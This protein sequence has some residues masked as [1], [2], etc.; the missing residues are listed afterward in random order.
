MFGC[1]KKLVRVLWE[2]TRQCNAKCIHCYSDSGAHQTSAFTK[3]LAYSVAQQLVDLKCAELT[4]TGGEFFLYPHWKELLHFFK[5]K[6]IQ[7]ALVTNGLLV[8]DNILDILKS[9]G[10]AGIGVS[11]DGSNAHTHDTIRQTPG[12]FDKA[13][14]TIQNAQSKKI[15]A[16][17]IT[18]INKLNITEL[19]DLRNFLVQHG[20]RTWQIQPCVLSGRMNKDLCIDAFGFYIMGLFHAQ[21]SRLYPDNRLK[22]IGSPPMGFY[23]KTIPAP[24]LKKCW[25][26]CTAGK[27]DLGIRANGDVVGCVSY[28]NNGRTEGN[29]KDSSLT[30]ILKNKD[31]CGWNRRLTHF[32]NLTGFCKKCPYSV[33]CLGGCPV[34]TDTQKH[35]Y[36]AIERKWKETP[37]D[38]PQDKILQALTQGH[39]NPNGNFYL[40]DNTQ[41]TNAFIDSLDLDE[42]HQ[43]IL[44]IIALK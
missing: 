37:A 6:N 25:T 34:Y 22:I 9:A 41:I 7:T 13:V 16:T 44:K 1:P 5:G 33:L 21:T 19:K 42:Y 23:S 35:C 38:T 15:P 3:D 39:M 17:A 43:N 24:F 11:I 31:F 14:K 12:C 20:F 28:F 40:K 32:K 4:F 29:V 10:V 36:Y 18:T 27:I 2:I 30:D 8:S 26:G